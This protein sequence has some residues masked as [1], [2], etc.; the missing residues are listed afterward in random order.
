MCPGPANTI[1]VHR[2]VD[3]SDSYAAGVGLIDFL[4]DPYPLPLEFR[5]GLVAR[6]RRGGYGY[7]PRPCGCRARAA[8]FFGYL[9]VGII[10]A[11][12]EPGSHC[13]AAQRVDDVKDP[14]GRTCQRVPQRRG[15][16]Q[17]VRRARSQPV[18][19]LFNARLG[20]EVRDRKST[21]LNSSHMSI[22]Y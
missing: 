11:R 4:H 2:A 19:Y 10:V 17:A 9:V 21:R 20:R 8:E 6:T 16:E 1:P 22:S 15:E 3:G 7:P 14:V 5:G 12:E 13:L 18:A